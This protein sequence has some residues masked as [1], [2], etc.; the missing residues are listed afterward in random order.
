MSHKLECPIRQPRFATQLFPRDL[1]HRLMAAVSTL[2]AAVLLAAPNCAA[3]AWETVYE[4]DLTQGR[5]FNDWI[6]VAGDWSLTSEGMKK[7]GASDGLLML[8]VPVVKGAVR[9]DYEAKSDGPPWDLSLYLGVRDMDYGGAAFL[10]FGSQENTT[11]TLRVPGAPPVA[12]KGPLVKPGQWHRITVLREGG[13]LSLQVDGSSVAV[14]EDNRG[15]YPG[16]YLGLFCKNE[17]VFRNVKV[18]RRDDPELRQSL[19][20][21]AVQREAGFTEGRFSLQNFARDARQKEA[22]RDELRYA[23]MDVQVRATTERQ[24]VYRQH[25]KS[26]GWGTVAKTSHGDIVA[27]FTGSREGED[28]PYGDIRFARSSTEGR[29]WSAPVVVTDSPLS[30]RDAGIVA[31]QSGHLLVTWRTSAGLEALGTFEPSGS[32]DLARGLLMPANAPVRVDATGKVEA[33][34]AELARWKA[35]QAAFTPDD[36]KQHVGF[37]S[38]L[39]KDDGKTWS[40]RMPTPVHS[41]HGPA[42]LR[43][44]RLLYLGRTLIDGKPFLAAAESKDEGQS[45]QVVWKQS[46]H[47]DELL[48]IREPHA[49]QCPDGRIVAVFR[50]SPKNW[51]RRGGEHALHCYISDKIWQIESHD[52]GRTWTRPKITP[53]WGYPPHLSVLQDGRLLCTYGYRHTF[54]PFSQKACVSHDGGKTWD[55]EHEITLRGDTWDA[56]FGFP[57][58]VETD[59]GQILSLYSKNEAT[60][61]PASIERTT[62]QVPLPPVPAKE[63]ATFRVE[64]ADPVLVATGPLEERRWGFYQFPG[65][66]ILPNGKIVGGYQTADDS[67]G[68]G[69]RYA[70][71]KFASLDGGKTWVPETEELRKERESTS[72]F[73]LKNGTT[74]QYAGFKTLRPDELGLKPLLR[75]PSSV[76]PDAE[77]YSYAD[78]PAEMRVMRIKR[79]APGGAEEEYD[80][81][82]Q[83]PDLGMARFKVGQNSETGLVALDAPMIPGWVRWGRGET[84]EL[85]DGTLLMLMG[86]I[87]VPEASNAAPHFATCLVA[88]TDGGQ[89][90]TYRSTI[91]GSNPEQRWEGTEEVSI[92]RRPN[93]TLVCVVRVEAQAAGATANLWITRST[94]DGHTWEQ[95]ERLNVHTALPGLIALDNGVVASVQGRPG[96]TLRFSNDPDCRDWSN[97]RVVHPAIGLH[98]ENTGWRDSTCGYTS[99][100]PLGPDRFLIV[101]SDFYHR[102]ENWTLHK[103]IMAREVKVS[104]N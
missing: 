90:W 35:R 27:A 5:A 23:R 12:G 6:P 92:V 85:T 45:W 31:L 98:Y 68:G 2:F 36:L 66:R 103:A 50:V 44:G 10:G 28:D 40:A 89:S 96:V 33:S 22:Q 93:G 70:D 61:Q 51:K 57:S 86:A 38:A 54:Y 56:H 39:S 58:S 84:C 24:P 101:Y 8:R 53:M 55:I 74:L 29:G 48:G 60:G 34:P 26:S 32:L 88:S 94:D 87:R 76:F 77:V 4:G 52:D 102:D 95:P 72:G 37:W 14:A 83:F 49:V 9:V 59:D 30:D 79:R 20:S 71:V 75:P 63:R 67:Y 17:G 19:S 21:E 104:A 25:E 43:D 18:Q 80:A 47:D 3:A 7:S 97:P 46:L 99:L 41:P 15:G 91:M 82:L 1:L 13:K 100:I 11:N 64:M 16:P 78:L 69:A 73:D 81:P 65:Y 42:V 62:W